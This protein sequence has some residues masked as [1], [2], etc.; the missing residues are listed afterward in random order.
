[1]VEGASIASADGVCIPSGV[2][3]A[4]NEQQVRQK[5]ST[6]SKVAKPR[7]KASAAVVSNIRE[8]SSKKEA[9]EAMEYLRYGKSRREAIRDVIDSV[10]A[11]TAISNEAD[12]GWWQLLA[13][14][15]S[16]QTG[17]ASSQTMNGEIY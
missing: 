2:A 3:D 10:V 12:E 1:M 13:P 4:T 14:A 11:K 5:A 16:Q 6:S 15:S 9:D 8:P 7:G 17:S